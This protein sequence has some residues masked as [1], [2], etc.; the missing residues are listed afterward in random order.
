ML[1][2]PKSPPSFAEA[3]IVSADKRWKEHW[4]HRVQKIVHWKSFARE[5]EKLYNPNE[6]RP[7]WD[8]VMLFRCLLLA[9]WNGLS[10]RAL[11]EALEFRI[12]F[13]KF[14]GLEVDAAV[15]DATTFVV[16]RDRI[17]PIRKRL[18]ERLDRQLRGAGF[19]VHRSIAVDA[20]LVE[21]HSKPTKNDDDEEGGSS[22]GDPD[23]SWRGF[24]VKKQVDGEGNEVISRRMALY[25]YKVNLAA[26]VGTGFV[27][28]VSV[29][30]ASEHE[31]HHLQ[32]FVRPG[33]R[34]VYADKGYVGNR[35][36]LKEEAI[37][38]GIMTKATR[39]HSLTQ[40]EQEHNA[41]IVKRRRIVEGVFGSWKQWYRWKKTRFM[42]LARNH[43]GVLLTAI[44]WN[45]KK[46]AMIELRA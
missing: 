14:A 44:A 13:K 27:S 21:A 36:Y 4:L 38:D 31:T 15:P 29:C 3:C 37:I 20:T 39:G 24:P 25:G 8:P 12:D 23:A 46:W 17:Q 43:L 16:F 11:E 5:L 34:R 2:K 6:G 9:E 32:E 18:F 26:S 40:Q 10:D 45:M 28:G 33:T 35:Q 22:G 30:R 19:Q 41:R 42:G 7:A 1:S